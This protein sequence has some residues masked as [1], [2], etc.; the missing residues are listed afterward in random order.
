M[1]DHRPLARDPDVAGANRAI[2]V[3][4]GALALGIALAIGWGA[5]APLH[6]AVIAEGHVRVSTHRQVVQHLDGGI[7]TEVLV[8]AGD[9]VQKGQPLMRVDDTQTRAVAAVMNQDLDL[10]RARI[11]R[12]QA[13]SRGATAVSFPEE[14]ATRSDDPRVHEAMEGERRLFKARLDLFNT[15]IGALGKQGEEVRREVTSL[16]QQHERAGAKLATLRDQLERAETLQQT[17]YVSYSKLLDLRAQVTEAEEKREGYLVERA[18]AEQRGKEIELKKASLASDRIRQ[19]ADELKDATAKVQ[20]LSQKALPAMS[21]LERQTVRAPIAG[22]VVGLRVFNPQTVIQPGE[23]LM[24]IVPERNDLLVEAKVLPQQIHE[25]HEGQLA[26]VQLMGVSQRIVPHIPAKVTYVA[27]DAPAAP[28]PGTMNQIPYYLVELRIDRKALDDVPGLTL[29][30]GMPT[31][32][33]IQTRARTT[34]D[35]LLEPITNVIRRGMR[36]T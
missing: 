15:Q 18:K 1:T 6:G 36:E 4:S 10:Q 13:E 28:V 5:L 23:T 20:E 33:Y 12:L 8:K 30:P 19:A 25:V 9:R 32:V 3:A 35:Y 2:A 34:L 22:E 31:M 21:A 7:V 14:L 27:A 11:A 24:E 26:E 16:E 17:G 29:S